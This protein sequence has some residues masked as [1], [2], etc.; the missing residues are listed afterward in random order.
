M[1][2]HPKCYYDDFL[3]DKNEVELYETVKD[4]KKEIKK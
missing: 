3:K 2:I 1:M 4:L